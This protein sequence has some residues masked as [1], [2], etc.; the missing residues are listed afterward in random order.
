MREGER[1]RG[2]QGEREGG[3]RE[4]FLGFFFVLTKKNP[5]YPKNDLS[6][7]PSRRTESGQRDERTGC[8]CL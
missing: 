5:S 1:D 4:F 7:H 8:L 3:G 2:R 6:Q